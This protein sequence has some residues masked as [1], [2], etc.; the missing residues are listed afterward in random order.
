MYLLD[1][2]AAEASDRFA[3]DV[4]A[5]ALAAGALDVTTPP[6]VSAWGRRP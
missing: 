5:A 4:A 2:A 1:N 6:L 3:V